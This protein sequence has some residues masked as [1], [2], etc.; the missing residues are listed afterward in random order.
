MAK[1]PIDL[2]ALYRIED[3]NERLWVVAVI[4]RVQDTRRAMAERERRDIE[5][6]KRGR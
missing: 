2:G 1:V 6:A 3:P 5:K 4:E